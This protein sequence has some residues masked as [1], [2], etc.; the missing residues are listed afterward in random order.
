LI[1]SVLGVGLSAIPDVVNSYTSYAGLLG[2]VFS[3]ITGVLL[4]DYLFMKRCHID[5]GALFRRGDIYWYW[6]GFN[7]LAIAWTVMGFIIYMYV[8]PVGMMK[9]VSTVLICGFGYC[10]SA[11]LLSPYWPALARASLAGEQRESVEQLAWQLAD[12]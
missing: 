6:N 4:A 10:V 12:R 11:W 8:I 2:N 3:P 1:I 7:P 5:L 9:T